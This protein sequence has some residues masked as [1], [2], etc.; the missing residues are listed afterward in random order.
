MNPRKDRL[1]LFVGIF[2]LAALIVPGSRYLL[3][4]RDES[5]GGIASPQERTRSRVPGN[6]VRV[7]VGFENEEARKRA[8]LAAAGSPEDAKSLANIWVENTYEHRLVEELLAPFDR[9]KLRELV[10]D[11][12]KDAR[13][14]AELILKAAAECDESFRDL[15][16]RPELREDDNVAIALDTYDYAVNNNGEALDRILKG[17]IALAKENRG[18][19][20]DQLWALGHVNEWDKI[21]AL[22]QEY[23]WNGDG[24][25]GDAQYAFWLKRMYL[26]PG[27]KRFPSTQEEFYQQIHPPFRK[28]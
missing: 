7:K 28:E 13:R 12:G 4:E 6:A 10:D 8:V 21:P 5:T 19:D 24:A 9:K 26:Y 20:T 1:W 22:F 17:Q 23:R 16:D 27:N 18:G 15:L 11:P 25:G 3:R 14:F 2:L